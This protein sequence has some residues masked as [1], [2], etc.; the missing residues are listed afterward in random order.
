MEVKKARMAETGEATKLTVGSVRTVL[1]ALFK[2]GLP[3]IE[4]N[5]CVDH[6]VQPTAQPLSGSNTGS[7]VDV[8][9]L[10]TVDEF[11]MYMDSVLEIDHEGQSNGFGVIV[12]HTA[13]PTAQFPTT[14]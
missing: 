8:F 5:G 4:S 9:E 13:Q 11:H 2:D 12:D 6:A 3:I 7:D 10:K 1:A 14:T